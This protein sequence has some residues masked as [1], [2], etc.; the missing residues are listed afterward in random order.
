[1]VSLLR[2]RFSGLCLHRPNENEIDLIHAVPGGGHPPLPEHKPQLWVEGD[3][4][5]T[6]SRPVEQT[7]NLCFV[8][9]KTE[10]KLRKAGIYSLEPDERLEVALANPSPVDPSPLAATSLRS[11]HESI[12]DS[13][14][15]SKTTFKVTRGKWQPGPKFDVTWLPSMDLDQL[16]VW[17]ELGIEFEGPS[18]ELKSSLGPACGWKLSPTNGEVVIWLT[19]YPTSSK[20]HPSRANQPAIHFKWFYECVKFKNGRPKHLEHPR[21][22]EDLPSCGEPVR[23]R[24]PTGT[25]FCPD[26]QYP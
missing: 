23:P 2:I 13:R 10:A 20:D 5:P 1:M 26:A 18:I 24:G 19:S 6:S 22:D 8:E 14:E 12:V 25:V 16:A 15:C 21:L 17:N 11:R 9:S 7:L 3:E 4:P